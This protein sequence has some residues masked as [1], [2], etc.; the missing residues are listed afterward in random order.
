MLLLFI[1]IQNCVRI[2]LEKKNLHI[3]QDKEHL[4]VKIKRIF[5]YNSP[6]L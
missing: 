1:I 6:S 4:R 2:I 5:Y 3:N